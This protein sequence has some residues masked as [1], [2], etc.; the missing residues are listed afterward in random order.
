MRIAGVSIDAVM[1][2]KVRTFLIVLSIVVGIATLTVI[3]AL[4]QGANKLIMERIQNF[5]PDAIMVHSGGWKI[6]GI[7]GPSTVDEANLTKKDI[8]DIENIE[9]VKFVSPFQV[10]YDMPIKYGNKFTVSGVQGV[11]PDWKDAWRR[12]A[13]KGEFITNSDNELLS[14]VCVIGATVAKELFGEADPIGE[15]I[16]IENISFKVVGILEKKG[17]SSSGGDA[18]DTILIPFT[19]ASRRLMNQPLYTAM[20][21][22][23]IYNPSEAQHIDSQIR[24]ILR[25]NHRLAETEEDDFH[26]TTAEELAKMVKSTSQTLAI[27]LWL[28]GIISPFV[29][30]IVLMNIMLMA[31]SERKREI[32]LRRALGAK[33]KHIIFQFLAESLVLTFAGGVLGV[34]AGIIIAILFSLSGKPISITWQPFAIAFIFSAVIGLFFGIY[35]A[36]KAA[37]LDPAGAL[38]QK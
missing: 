3:V 24:E 22:V 33:K 10:K 25:R 20:A 17:Q 12:G 13:S 2:H 1:K 5:G 26:N 23:I 8:S 19:T 31:V 9:G 6:R 37:E 15:N 38:A 4:T 16:L 30:G 18:D 14:K 34:I 11:E 35:P 21:R 29:G 27:F 28:V 7:R 32:G 36:R